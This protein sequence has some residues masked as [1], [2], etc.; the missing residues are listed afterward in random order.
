[1]AHAAAQLYNCE[2]L[3]VYVRVSLPMIRQP[4]LL[5]RSATLFWGNPFCFAI[6]S[7]RAGV[8]RIHPG[9]RRSVARRVRPAPCSKTSTLIDRSASDALGPYHEVSQF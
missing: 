6:L 1:M 3:T 8:V 7:T 9:T 5:R 4:H 2:E